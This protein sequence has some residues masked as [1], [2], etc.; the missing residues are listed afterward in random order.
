MWPC[1]RPQ[2]EWRCVP[3]VVVYGAGERTGI[4]LESRLGDVQA[5][6]RRHH[7][8]RRDDPV[9]HFLMLVAHTRHNRGVVA[10]F[11][12]LMSDFFGAWTATVLESL[13]SGRHPVSGLVLF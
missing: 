8:K 6:T 11:Q 3:G 9:D 2:T 13:S 10:E 4:E 5:T 7:L 12:P 1:H